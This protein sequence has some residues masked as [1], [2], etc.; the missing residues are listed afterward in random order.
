[1]SGASSPTTAS[2][3]VLYDKPAGVTSHDIVA[4][5]RRATARGV[6]VGH[7]DPQVVDVPRGAH[8]AV[9]DRFDTVAVGVEQEAAVVVAAVL[10]ARPGLA[11]VA[12]AGVDTGLPEA[13]DVRA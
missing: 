5:V 7:A 13:I 11:V 8:I 2:G 4:S 9:G 1:M 6:K 3:V 10:R 12:V